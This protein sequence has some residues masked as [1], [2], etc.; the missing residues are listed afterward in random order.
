MVFIP[1]AV[2]R[3]SAQPVG[4][5][6]RREAVAAAVGLSVWGFEWFNDEMEFK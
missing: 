4:A 3:A 5:A 1:V 6:G 2:L